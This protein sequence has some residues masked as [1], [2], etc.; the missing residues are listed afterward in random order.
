[1]SYNSGNKAGILSRF[2][3]GSWKSANSVGYINTAEY[4]QKNRNQFNCRRI[5]SSP[6]GSDSCLNYTLIIPF[7]SAKVN[8]KWVVS[9]VS[10]HHSDALISTYQSIYLYISLVIHLSISLNIYP[11]I[12]VFILLFVIYLY[13]S[14][15]A[16]SLHLFLSILLF[17]YLSLYLSIYPI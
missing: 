2:C 10:R 14:Y 8:K 13:K 3:I 6:L 7:F 9:S 12:Y 15:I 16:F 4:Q 11:S 5:E 17:V 1:M